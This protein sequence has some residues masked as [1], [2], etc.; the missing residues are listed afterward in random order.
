MVYACENYIAFFVI[1]QCLQYPSLLWLDLRGLHV[2]SSDASV[3][4]MALRGQ[5][6]NA[7]ELVLKSIG[8]E[9]RTALSRPIPRTRRRRIPSPEI[10]DELDAKRQ[11]DIEG[12]ART[13]D[14]TVSLSF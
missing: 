6:S 10:V 12:Y 11:L 5:I 9:S 3:L 2:G 13:L 7:R 1:S 14:Y 8:M 4:M